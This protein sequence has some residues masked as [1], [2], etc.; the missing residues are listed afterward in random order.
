MA[1]MIPSAINHAQGG[2]VCA[3]GAAEVVHREV[4][5]AVSYLTH[6]HAQGRLAHVRHPAGLELAH[7]QHVRGGAG[8]LLQLLQPVLDHRSLED[9]R[10]DLH[11]PGAARQAVLHVDLEDALEQPSPADALRLGRSMTPRRLQLE[12]HLLCRVDLDALRR[13]RGPGDGAAQPLQPLALGASRAAMYSAS[14]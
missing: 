1:H 13:Q 14:V 11:L 2:E 6:R 10:D 9:G 4:G 5:Q 7:R 3:G 8:Q 12:L